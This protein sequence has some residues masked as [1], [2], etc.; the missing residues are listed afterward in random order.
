LSARIVREAEAFDIPYSKTIARA[1][2]VARSRSFAAPLV[3]RPNT[4]CSAARPAR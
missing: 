1:T 2:S 4:I 3:T